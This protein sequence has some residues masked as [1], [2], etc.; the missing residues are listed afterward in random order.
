SHTRL[1]ESRGYGN[2]HRCHY[3][4]YLDGSTLSGRIAE[5]VL[6]TGRL[7]RDCSHFRVAVADLFDSLTS[8]LA[9]RRAIRTIRFVGSVAQSGIDVVSSNCIAEDRRRLCRASE[10]A[11]HPPAVRSRN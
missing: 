1:A 9:D 11:E 10:H 8:R 4:H 3:V 6:R 5:A 7:A 2:V